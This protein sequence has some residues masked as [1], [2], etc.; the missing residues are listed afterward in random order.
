MR[1]EV[2]V[3][4]LRFCGEKPCGVASGEHANYFETLHG[5]VL[6]TFCILF[7]FNSLP[8]P[9]IR[10][11]LA[12]SGFLCG[13]AVSDRQTG[14]GFHS[15]GIAGQEEKNQKLRFL[16]FSFAG[17]DYF[18]I[19]EVFKYKIKKMI[20]NKVVPRYIF[21]KETVVGTVIF[22][23][24]FSVLF[25]F[26]YTPFSETVW[27]NF[28]RFDEMIVMVAFY[29]VGI[30]ILLISKLLMYNYH[31]KHNIAVF[32]LLLWILTEVISIAFVYALFTALFVKP[33]LYDFLQI[34]FRAIFCI[35]LIMLIPYAISFL[36]ITARYQRKL[37]NRLGFNMM[38]EQLGGGTDTK[39]IHLADNTG[40][41]KLSL[42]VDSFYYTESQ[43][44]YVK[45]YYESEGKLCNYM[46]RCTTKNIE[47]RFGGELIRCH[48]SFL[49][50]K[51]KITF[52]KNDRNGMYLKLSNDHVKAIPVS[53]TY[54]AGIEA[55]LREPEKKNN[56][57]S[58]TFFLFS[59]VFHF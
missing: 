54:C 1:R 35:F 23:A 6:F 5:K 8:L 18:C 55:L 11:T 15:I 10:C 59:Y 49:V 38:D 37:L 46:L 47:D 52:F 57:F 21:E 7:H 51:N 12:T 20:F 43:D 3:N 24:L 28:R 36:Y 56:R 27:F 33:G 41:L 26:V 22:T 16:F 32:R 17:L 44:N 4:E 48:R 45:I 39:L 9:K 58:L 31:L 29:L 25:M 13:S 40:K 34:F 42:S 14:Y 30:S 2:V 19:Q 53:K 50:N